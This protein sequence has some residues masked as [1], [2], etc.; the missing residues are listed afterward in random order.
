MP[1]TSCERPSPAAIE[2]TRELGERLHVDVGADG[3]PVGVEILSPSLGAVDLEPL[4]DRYGLEL[5]V[6]FRFAA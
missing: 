1:S 3:Q 4:R 6:P 2:R 5:K